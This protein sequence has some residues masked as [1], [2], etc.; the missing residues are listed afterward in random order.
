MSSSATPSI[1]VHAGK[2]PPKTIVPLPRTSAQRISDSETTHRCPV[3]VD[4]DAH[5]KAQ[6]V[7]Y[8]A[9]GSN[10]ASSVFRGTRGIRPLSA[11]NVQVPTLRL[12]FDLSGIPYNEPCFGNTAIR[13]VPH[14]PVPP[15]MPRPPV[16]VLPVP[17]PPPQTDAGSTQEKDGAWDKGLVGVVYELTRE[18]YTHVIATEGGGASYQDILV[19][20]FPLDT[21][22]ESTPEIPQGMPFLAHTLFCPPPRPAGGKKKLSGANDSA[23][24]IDTSDDT[25]IDMDFLLTGPSTNPSAMTPVVRKPGYAQPSPRYAGLLITGADEHNLPN[26]YRRYLASIPTYRVTTRGQRIGQ[27][28]TTRF[29]RPLIF[30][31]FGLGRRT[32][33]KDGHYAPWFAFILRLAF[34]IM[35]WCYDTVEKP[36]LGDGERTM[37]GH[38][39][40]HAQSDMNSPPRVQKVLG[41]GHKQS[42]LGEETPLLATKL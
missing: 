13:K 2:V 33:D 12:T 35:W 15:S 38:S 19:P 25:E 42:T 11:I 34:S 4:R 37:P 28:I 3:P 8:L 36:L 16:P 1:A 41:V 14:K 30:N 24:T 18:D 39:D 17:N 27:A 9:Y 10:L 7:F 40:S 31:L 29:W 21:D 23:T 26:D 5:D 20:C 22:I 6:T 32:A